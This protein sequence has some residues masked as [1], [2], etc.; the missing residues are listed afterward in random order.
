MDI[1]DSAD[2]E[3]QRKRNQRKDGSI[4][5]KMQTM[6]SLIEPTETVHSPGGTFKKKRHIDDIE[7]DSPVEGEN[8]VVKHPSRRR[9]P[10]S[11]VD[12]NIARTGLGKTRR[13][14]APQATTTPDRHIHRKSYRS[15]CDQPASLDNSHRA[16]VRLW[17]HDSDSDYHWG[18]LA[19]FSDMSSDLG[20][21]STAMLSNP[22]LESARACIQP[23]LSPLVGPLWLQPSPQID[24]SCDFFRDYRTPTLYAESHMDQENL[25]PLRWGKTSRTIP[26]DSIPTTLGM[27]DEYDG[28]TGS[29]ADVYAFTRNPLSDVNPDQ[30]TLPFTPQNRL[31]TR[32]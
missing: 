9:K 11:L 32:S 28:S 8:P 24:G 27:Y 17:R 1:F 2:Q 3:T 21:T 10:L 18:D 31:S 30:K 4:L 14:A 13:A 22:F 6:S 16:A 20:N 15:T 25:N 19:T 29:L 26:A 5:G 7:D 12:K 23:E